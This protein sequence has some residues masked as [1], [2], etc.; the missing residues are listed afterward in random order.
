M[1][2]SL[3]LTRALAF[4]TRAH[5]GQQRKYT[6]EPYINHPVE[7][8]EIVRAAGGT[9]AMQAAALLHDVVEDCGI[10]PA[11]ILAEFGDE[12]AELVGWL[13]DVSKPEDGN[14]SVRKALDRAHIAQAPPA[15]QTVKLAD[16]ISNS[17]TILKWGKGFA[18]I[19]IREMAL[20]LDVLVQGD[21]D[22]LRKARSIVVPS[23]IETSPASEQ[24]GG[25]V[26]EVPGYRAS[27]GGRDRD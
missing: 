17:G 9:E 21:A 10:L 24:G 19:Y 7:V 26:M 8:A 27:D 15:A 18:R 16:L 25:G 22:L 2:Q 12:V 4:A 13:T 5:E 14:R 20:L 6:G 23:I 11:G 1:E 3:L